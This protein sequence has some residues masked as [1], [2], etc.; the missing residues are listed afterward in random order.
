[1]PTPAELAIASAIARASHSDQSRIR[2]ASTP[3]VG[4][5]DHSAL[6]AEVD[7][8]EKS[9][10][11]IVVWVKSVL[12]GSDRETV[13]MKVA[14]RYDLTSMP[15]FADS[16]SDADMFAAWLMAL[17]GCP[18]DGRLPDGQSNPD[19]K[20]A[21]LITSVV[22]TRRADNILRGLAYRV[23]GRYA[24][25][26]S[27]KF[28]VASDGRQYEIV[29]RNADGSPVFNREKQRYV[30]LSFSSIETT[31]AEVANARK[32]LDEHFPIAARTAAAPVAP[33]PAD[34]QVPPAKFR[35]P[36]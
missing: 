4:P 29:G 18:N 3:F 5:G 36:T 12:T 32:W 16:A 28:G 24:K 30:Y 6:V 17:T 26:E 7:V 1:M 15:R 20:L 34:A 25:K 27:P 11:Q 22:S 19:S 9:T 10:G 35:L 14:A 21:A 2:G 8:D 23:S 13:P 33:A 31:D